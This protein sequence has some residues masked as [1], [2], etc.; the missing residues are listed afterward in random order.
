[1][2]S[3][4][5]GPNVVP[6]RLVRGLASAGQGLRTAL[7]TALASEPAGG[8]LRAGLSGLVPVGEEAASDARLADLGAQAIVCALLAGRML[9]EESGSVGTLAATRA[10]LPTAAPEV[11]GLFEVAAIESAAAQLDRWPGAIAGEDALTA[12]AEAFLRAYDPGQ[13]RRRGVF[14]TP[15]PVVEAIVEEVHALLQ[16]ELGLTDGLAATE[17]WGEVA[18]REPIF[19]IPAGAAADEP[20]VAVLDFAA[21]TGTFLRAC[22]AVIERTMKDRWCREL[23]AAGWADPRI[24]ARWRAYV[25]RHV[26]PRLSG[27]EI[28]AAPALLAR[29]Q[30][31]VA[32]AR[33]GCPGAEVRGMVE[34]R[35]ALAAAPSRRFTVIVGNPPYGPSQSVPEWL[36][37]ALG[38]WKEGLGET[39]CDLVREEWKFLRLAEWTCEQVPRAVAGIVIN[40]D[41]LDGIAKRRLRESL[42]T[43]FP[44]RR[45]IDLHGEV[46]G[47]VVDDNVFAIAQGVAI[48][49]LCRGPRAGHAVA[50][51]RGRR[52]EKL[53]LLA[54]RARISA[55]ARPVAPRGPYFRWSM[56]EETGDGADEYE[57][58]WPLPRIF[59][60]YGSGIQSKNDRVCVAASAAEVLARVRLLAR[61]SEA[62]VRAALPIPEGG[63]WSL[64]AAQAELRA[65]G[66]APERVRR[67]L[68]R[69]FDWRWTYLSE[70]S[71]GFLGRPRAA[72]MRHLDGI[73]LGLIY[74]RQVVGAATSHFLVTRD[75]I[76]HG[77][78]Y[79]GS[80]GQ[81][82]V[83]PLYLRG[84][85]GRSNLTEGFVQAVRAA[86]GTEATP[87]TLLAY[88][89]AVVHSPTYRARY[90]AQVMRDFAR[91]PIAGSA[92]LLHELAE[93][94]ARLVGLH[95]LE[96]ARPEPGLAEWEGPATAAIEAVTWSEGA[97]FVD[98]RRRCGF[99]GVPRAVWELRVGGYAPCEK[100]LK[101]RRGSRIGAAE[102]E[103]VRRTAAALRGTIALMAE[104]DAT[105]ARYGGW[106]GA[107]VN[108]RRA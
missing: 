36:A 83:A 10:L 65:L 50:S 92:G 59:G 61:A 63:A 71:G 15:R 75:P 27:Y 68:Y 19:E 37:A 18:G 73:G 33:S 12:C 21:G 76:C 99:S 51:V 5:R 101:A 80:R 93:I 57:G 25:P 2:A 88:V 8:P 82:F 34:V 104:V 54:D 1:M 17:T 60:V 4:A 77:T 24:V 70:R 6:D 69:P 94:G 30:L 16:T 35:D 84:D 103:H 22:V 53:A 87:E 7:S 41:L 79:L 62:E 3:A 28:M 106:P 78:L 13:R 67:I 45:I 31:A 108:G 97:V 44:L 11:G 43:T 26:V 96:T 55:L 64:A 20:F 46:R 66:P 42:Q 40:R 95:L 105:I 81:D 9:S 48:A 39:K 100:W 90:R 56:S 86:T 23:G 58:W 32:L 47:D 91:V 85:D 49:L 74:N 89:Y 52:A 14:Y 29:L 38:R 72:L 107:F 102:I 98:R